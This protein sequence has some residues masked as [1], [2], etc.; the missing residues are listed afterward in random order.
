[1]ELLERLGHASSKAEDGSRESAGP[2][3]LGRDPELR[4]RVRPAAPSDRELQRSLGPRDRRDRAG[5][6]RRSRSASPTLGAARVAI[7]YL[8][9]DAAAAETAE[10]LDGARRGA[11]PRPR[12]RLLRAR[13]GRGRRARAA[14][15]ARPQRRDRRDPPRAR[16]RGQAL[17]LD[18]RRERPRAALPRASCGAAD[19][20]PAAR[21]SGSRA[22]AR[23][24]CSRT[25]R[26]SAPRR[27]RSRRSS[28]T[29]PSSWRRA[30]SASTPS[31]PASSR[32]ARSTTSR[33]A[34]R[35]SSMGARNPAGRLVSPEDVAAAVAVPLLAR[36]RDG[37][38]PDARRRRRLLAARLGGAD[39]PQ[40]ARLRRRAS[41]VGERA[42]DARPAAAI[43]ERLAGVGGSRVLHLFCGIG[44]RDDRAGRARRAR[45]RCR[46]GRGRRRGGA[47]ARTG[48]PVAARRCRTRCRRRS[49]SAAGIS[50]TSGPGRWRDFASR[51]PGR[52]GSPRRCGAAV[53]CSSTTCIPRRHAS[54]PSTAGAAT[55]SP[56]LGW[57]GGLGALVGAVVDA[58]LVAARARGVAGPQPAG[59]GLRPARGRQAG[60]VGP[61][62]NGEPDEVQSRTRRERTMGIGV[63][64]LLI[65]AGAVLTWGVTAEVEGLD[66]S[67]IGVILMIVGLLG[68]VLSIIFWQSWGGVPPP[69]RVRR[70]RAR[71]PPYGRHPHP[72][73]GGGRRR[74]SR[75]ARPAASLAAAATSR[76]SVSDAT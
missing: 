2:D 51:P 47:A 26:S 62:R 34:R 14:R 28:A 38:R 39:R 64:I 3:R 7:G 56:G 57:A 9:S 65:A 25:T 30:G 27:R 37:A 70:G 42:G 15:R 69:E 63:S 46:R 35:C 54:T 73:R 45:D 20:V 11:D 67:A 6:A 50:S 44:A 68:L 71:P 55:T 60:G 59:P 32:P 52:A 76:P 18:A 1:M 13:A 33:T 41:L 24:A 74:R 21:S 66:V 61:A 12:Q 4:A 49:C 23:S 8:R 19:A 36:R 17:G 43:R 53:C 48:A 29:S 75:P 31:P 40:P 5:S 10:E 16:D 22:S 58:G 72:H